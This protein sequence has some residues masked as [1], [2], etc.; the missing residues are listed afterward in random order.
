MAAASS[1]SLMS[2]FWFLVVLL[3]VPV[4][5]WLLKR[6]GQGGG[7]A[8]LA[9]PGMRVVGNLALG[10]GQRLVTVEMGE[11]AQR[12]WLVLGVTA[13][14]ITP[15][16]SIDAPPPLP[17]A[18]APGVPGVPFAELLSRWRA[19]VPGRS[20]AAGHRDEK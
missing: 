20:H 16:R 15:L 3:L 1:A 12:R 19:A 4:G 17:A 6:S 5:L 2:A 10:P 7:A 14:N 9:G 18:Q 8:R 13:H 11:G